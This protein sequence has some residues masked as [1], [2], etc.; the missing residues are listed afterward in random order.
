LCAWF[1]CRL[2]VPIDPLD[3]GRQGFVPRPKTLAIRLYRRPSRAVLALLALMLALTLS[4]A[5]TRFAERRAGTLAEANAIGTAWL[6]AVAVGGPHGTQIVR[7]LEECTRVRSESRIARVRGRRGLPDLARGGEAAVVISV[8]IRG[9]HLCFEGAETGQ[10]A[11]S[12]PG[13]DGVFDA[14]IA[15]SDKREWPTRGLICRTEA[16]RLPGV[17]RGGHRILGPWFELPLGA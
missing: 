7:L 13:P 14:N 15:I 3:E 17:R 9:I 1:R 12:E 8:C 11:L 10:K 16:A 6:R 4:F 5:N 2:G